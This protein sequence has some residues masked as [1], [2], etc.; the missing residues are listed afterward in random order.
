MLETT[1]NTELVI[2]DL[3]GERHDKSLKKVMKL[4]EEPSFGS[5]SKMDIQYTSGKGRVETL[6]TLNLTKKQ[7]IAVGA[8][9]NNKLLMTVID[10]LEELEIANRKPKVLLMALELEENELDFKTR[11]WVRLLNSPSN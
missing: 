8:K 11:Y 7:A 10:R 2:T 6:E 4:A 3:I 9:L 5:L 1:T